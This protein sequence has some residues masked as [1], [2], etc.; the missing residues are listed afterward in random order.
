MRRFSTWV[1]TVKVEVEALAAPVLKL[2]PPVVAPLGTVAVIWVSL[3]IVNKALVPLK[4]T[5]V[6]LFKLVPVR[7]TVAPTN[8]LLGVKPV[9]VGTTTL[10][11]ELE[12]DEEELLELEELL[13]LV[14]VGAG[15]RGIGCATGTGTGWGAIGAEEG[16]SVLFVGGD[17]GIGKRPVGEGAPLFVPAA[18]G[19]PGGRTGINVASGLGVGTPRGWRVIS[20]R[21]VWPP[22]ITTLRTSTARA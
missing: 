10:S 18:G 17:R 8:P 15:L 6:T 11:D 22:T 4:A 3:T 21:W 20:R 7:V 19:V 1:L 2:M 12:L 16:G 13:V 5:P 9:T 14:S